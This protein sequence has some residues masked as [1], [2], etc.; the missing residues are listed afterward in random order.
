MTAKLKVGLLYDSIS[1]N[2]GDEAIG[3]AMTQV[4][5]KYKDIQTEVVNPF[6][7]NENDYAKIIIG[8]G[9]LLRHSGDPFYDKFRLNGKHILNAV[10]LSRPV[11]DL[12]YLNQYDFVSTRTQD[13]TN[14]VQQYVSR[15]DTIPDITTFMTHEDYKIEGISKDEKVVGIHIVPYTYQLCPEVVEIINSIP[16]KKVFIPFTHYLKDKHFMESLPFDFS[17]SIILDD[18]S[19]VQLHSVIS[20]MS[21]VVVSSLHASIFAFT[22]NVPFA[23]LGQEKVR[24][25]F[26][27]RG[28]NGYVFN[29]SSQ[30]KQVIKKLELNPPNFTELVNK[31]R[32][33][34]E[35]AVEKYVEIIRTSEPKVKDE[36]RDEGRQESRKKDTLTHTL[37]MK[38]DLANNVIEARDRLISDLI[39][40]NTSLKFEIDSLQKHTIELHNLVQLSKEQA[41]AYHYSKSFRLGYLALHPIQIPTKAVN[42]SRKL[43]KEVITK[44]VNEKDVRY[45]RKIYSSVTSDLENFE[46]KGKKL[47]VVVHLYYLDLWPFISDKLRILNQ[48]KFDIFVSIPM[49]KAEYKTVIESESNN[50]K[51]FLTPNKGRDVLPFVMIAK[52]L[53]KMRYEFV[54]KIHSKKSKHRDDGAEWM[55]QIVTDLLPQDKG[56]LEVILKTLS[57]K[58]TGLI[59]PESEYVS[60]LVNYPSNRLGIIKALSRNFPLS[61]ID[62]IDRNRENFG[63]FAGTMFW[64]RVDALN[65]VLQAHGIADFEKESGQIDNTYAHALERVFSLNSEIKKKNIFGLSRGGQ[66]KLLDYSTANIPDWSDLKSK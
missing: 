58:R 46:N 55:E 52:H 65:E 9:Q 25:Y 8:G 18:L 13:E 11:D 43:I 31:D 24:S 7:F 4:L 10:G 62:E 44:Q 27:D 20:Q 28:L 12:D 5:S 63:F 15:V 37:S 50:I 47:A 51:V 34:L 35:R 30:L 26:T 42:R 17:N 59:A 48:D 29:N 56:S 32:L 53:K 38:A 3:I 45:A 39:N 57:K 2:S 21:Y 60:L 22:Q 40:Q 66:I 6:D 14:T 16:H 49:E 54:L 41:D 61:T 1:K 19:P 36:Y 23:T 33:S 64:A